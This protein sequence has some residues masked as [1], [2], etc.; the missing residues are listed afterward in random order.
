MDQP[1]W[2][3]VED[4][5]WDPGITHNYW[6]LSA[7]TSFCG[8]TYAIA[9]APQVTV[10]VQ[11]YYKAYIRNQGDQVFYRTS[12][13]CNVP[14][15]LLYDFGLVAGDTFVL[16][17][18]VWGQVFNNDTSLYIVQ[19]VDTNVVLG[20]ARRRLQLIEQTTGLPIEWY[21][22]VGS[23]HHPFYALLYLGTEEDLVTLC[24]D[25]VQLPAFTN[26]Y[27]NTCSLIVAVPEAQLS[28]TEVYP[29]PS[30][31]GWKVKA[32]D[33]E[34]LELIEIY[35]LQGRLVLSK[36]ISGAVALPVGTRET[37]IPRQA[38]SGIYLLRMHTYHR[39][40]SGK[41]IQTD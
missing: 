37:D 33:G 31:Q 20:T 6:T 35:D 41:L 24:M 36:G 1:D 22:G 16:D 25:S 12:T 14:D 4:Y 34:T 13:D 21:Y 11:G 32:P 17:H 30:R 38:E 2:V 23:L 39:T 7:D 15:K 9:S 19:Q 27:Q 28:V 3:V 40:Y 5:F 26:P 18:S 8:D 10:S 29:N